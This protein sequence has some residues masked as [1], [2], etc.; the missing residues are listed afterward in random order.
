MTRL[1]LM[2]YNVHTLRDDLGALAEVVSA[3]AP[4]VVVIQEAPRRFRW[5]ARCADLAHRLG[6]LYA[7]GGLP[8]LGNLVL[9]NYRVRVRGHWCV[10]YPLTPG[11]HMRGAVLVRCEVARTN[12]VVAGSHLA[13]DAGERPAQA[14]ILRRTLAAVAEPTLLGIDLNDV[15]GSAAWRIVADGLVDSGAARGEGAVGGE[16]TFPAR[17]PK[18]RI[19]AIMVDPRWVVDSFR[20]FDHPR[21]VQASDH[22]PLVVDVRVDKTS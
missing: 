4:D 9:T 15:P 5:R 7:G 18:R 11:R 13:T 19:D 3:A 14:E 17:A 10:Q 6:L 2:S 22:R 1:R 16:P 8:S 12:F 21:A 20:V